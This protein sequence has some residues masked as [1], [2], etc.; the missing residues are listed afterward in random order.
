M[1]SLSRGLLLGLAFAI[2]WEYSVDLGPPYGNL[3]RIVGALL[4]LAATLAVLREGS[5]RRPEALHWLSLALFL[6]LC[7]SALWTV[8]RAESLRQLRTYAQEVII[9]WAAWEFLDTP[10]HMRNLVRAYV[11]GA[12][13]LAGLTLG[14]FAA[15]STAG[16]VRFAP[17]G[18]D[19]NDAA[20]ILVFAL[21]LAALLLYSECRRPLRALAGG[22][23][24][25]GTLAVFLTASRS[26]FLAAL[27]ALSGSCVLLWRWGGRRAMAALVGI[28]LLAAS[29][30]LTVPAESLSRLGTIA[31]EL[32]GG[33]LNQRWNIWEAGWQ[34][35]LRTPFCGSGVGSFVTA[36]RLAPLD[37]AHSTAVGL[38][39]EGGIVALA[40]AC[41]LLLAVMA[42][43]LRTHGALRIVLASVVAVGLLSSLVATV[44]ENR[45]TWLLLGLVS[46]AARLTVEDAAGIGRMFA[47]RED[48]A[49]LPACVSTA[50]RSEA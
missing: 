4:I 18:H 36:A 21:P 47:P 19:P 6:W 23:L 3:A 48:A 13:V 35:F 46:V 20:R 40:I 17:E 49:Q 14:T 42:C 7:C 8:D 38:A 24:L 30:W 43:V 39:V 5:L 16:Q 10:Q 11:A 29:V 31:A 44:Q 15:A 37:T 32:Q 22:Y 27:V 12:A 2:P 41:A 45:A 28:P 26:G 1:R 50:Y 9:L 33:N 34:A 25:F